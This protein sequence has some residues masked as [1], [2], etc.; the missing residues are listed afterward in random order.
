[1]KQHVF[2]NYLNIFF[3][4]QL[5]W[6]ESSASKL[7]Q[8]VGKLMSAPPADLLNNNE[9]EVVVFATR[10]KSINIYSWRLQPLN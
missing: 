9:Q 3:Y 10:P 2:Y 4:S 7:L 6:I 1:M 8:I 5:V